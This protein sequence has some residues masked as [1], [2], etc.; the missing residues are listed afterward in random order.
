MH[1]LSCICNK[2][3]YENAFSKDPEFFRFYRSLEAY[4][5]TFDG[6]NDM[7][8]IKPDSDF[9]KYMKQPTDN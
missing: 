5:K 8:V 7:L 6:N 4:R 9:F 1:S 2:N 3:K